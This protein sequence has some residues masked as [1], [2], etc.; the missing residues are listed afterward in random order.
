MNAALARQ[1]EFTRKNQVATHRINGELASI[2][3]VWH[4]SANTDAAN[5]YTDVLDSRYEAPPLPELAEAESLGVDTGSL[6]QVIKKLAAV[7]KSLAERDELDAY[8]AFARNVQSEYDRIR[9]ES[10][11]EAAEAEAEEDSALAD[12]ASAEASELCAAM[13]DD[14]EADGGPSQ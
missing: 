4:I 11:E 8:V 7:E 10:A 3:R 6:Q 13:G 14:C 9:E 5:L 2:Q 12:E 1:R